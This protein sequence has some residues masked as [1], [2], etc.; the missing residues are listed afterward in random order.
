MA[1]AVPS[2]EIA[3]LLSAAAA[4]R[5]SGLVQEETR[6][7]EDAHRLAPELPQILNALGM[8]AL[9]KE[10]NDAAAGWFSRATANDPEAPEL[11][12]NL[13]K[14]QRLTGDDAGELNSLQSAIACDQTNIMAWLRKAELHQRLNE[15][16]PAAK[17]W[18]MVVGLSRHLDP[19]PPALAE[20]IARGHAFVDTYKTSLGSAVD[21]GLAVERAGLARGD[22]RRFDAA[23][24][25]LLGR[26]S[27]YF[28]SCAGLHFPFLPADE[29]F[30]REY[31]PWL[32]QIEARTDTIRAELEALISSRHGGFR[33]YVRLDPGTPQN[34]WSRLDHSLDW[35]A[36][37]LW[38]YGVRN[39]EVCALCPVTAATLDALPRAELPGRAPSAFFS[40]LKPR[41]H[42]PPHTGVSNTRAIIHLP[43]I[44]PDGCRFRVGGE[45]RSWKVGEAFAFDDTIE[46]E[47]WNDS[48]D[49]RAVL[50]FDVWNP[51]LTET[52][53]H[54]L[55][56]FYAVA[57]AS[58]HNP[59][60]TRTS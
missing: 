50:I 39:D 13:A 14:A 51:Y 44:V 26:R 32:H 41:S 33:P 22:L 53:R 48:D 15:I 38:E 17:A 20:I 45:T 54:L 16:P 4:A 28:N 10:D 27:I 3:R 12:L 36:L 60:P 52:E 21:E 49:L 40:L 59:E 29:F 25:C 56:R 30:D 42:I 46:H 31:F 7:L 34:L 8:L 11:W 9:A 43:L 1:M 2:P 58:G 57:D 19:V 5:Q 37:F 47:A 18:E 6:L 24:D 55:Q 23:V 35:S